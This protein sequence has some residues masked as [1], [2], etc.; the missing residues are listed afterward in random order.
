MATATP[1]GYGEAHGPRVRL[2][3]Y[4]RQAQLQYTRMDEESKK[5]SC[6]T[7]LLETRL[8][9][10]TQFQYLLYT[11]KYRINE[12]RS[13]RTEKWLGAFAGRVQ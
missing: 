2:I 6:R 13:T 8:E 12:L 5:E 11:I 3:S 9:V 4:A 7:V 10:R 1:L